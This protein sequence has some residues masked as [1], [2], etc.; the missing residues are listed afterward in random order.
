MEKSKRYAVAQGYIT[1]TGA[2]IPHGHRDLARAGKAKALTA[3]AIV[4]GQKRQTKPSHEFLH[5]QALDDE[6]CDKLHV[7]KQVPIHPG[8][9]SR[10]ARG[11]EAD[12]FDVLRKASDT[13][14]FDKIG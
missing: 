12:G 9:K 2:F 5:G 13:K 14:N 3:P 4:A 8:M 1:S 6:T 7:G 11:K 10:S